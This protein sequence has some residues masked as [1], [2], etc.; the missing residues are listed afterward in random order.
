MERKFTA[1]NMTRDSLKLWQ[2]LIN[3]LGVTLSRSGSF[4]IAI[5]K[6]FEKATMEMYDVIKIGR[7]ISTY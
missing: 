2:I 4:K 1:T 7:M 6:L 5:Q 3:Y